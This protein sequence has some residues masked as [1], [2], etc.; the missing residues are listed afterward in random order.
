[1]PL[2]TH[3]PAHFLGLLSACTE[4]THDSQRVLYH[5]CFSAP[6]VWQCF[7]ALVSSLRGT[8]LDTDWDGSVPEFHSYILYAQS[9]LEVFCG[10]LGVSLEQ[11]SSLDVCVEWVT[12]ADP[13]IPHIQL[14]CSIVTRVE[15]NVNSKCCGMLIEE[16]LFQSMVE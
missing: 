15:M 3:C 16:H 12:H 4:L 7:T 2:L 10:F 13:P 9:F 6:D 1:M 14:P 8:Q 11:A 5:V